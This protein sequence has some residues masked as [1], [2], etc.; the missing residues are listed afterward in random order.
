MSPRST[1]VFDLDD[2]LYLENDYVKSGFNCVG[3]AFRDEV[4]VDNFSEICFRLHQA[5]QRGRIFDAALEAIGRRPDASIIQAMVEL[6]RRHIPAI[7]LSTRTSEFLE[8]LSRRFNL[9]LLT[10]GNIQTQRAKVEALGIAHY[11]DV[12]VFA[13]RHGPL[14]D[15]P[16]PYG[17]IELE[18]CMQRHGSDITY[19]AD[20]PAKDGPSSGLRGWKWI[21]I[22]LRG[23]LYE[24]SPTPL[25]IKEINEVYE[26]SELLSVKA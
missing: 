1:L 9:G 15:K 11:F 21:R 18:R 25:G 16:H 23:S 22:R 3:R 26:L 10:G 12:I 6:Y 4:G 20:N 2:T 8:T 14:F 17:W 7:S 5:G 19:V 24:T 13:G